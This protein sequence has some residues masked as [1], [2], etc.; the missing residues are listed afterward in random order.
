MNWINNAGCWLTLAGICSMCVRADSLETSKDASEAW[1]SNKPFA[2]GTWSTSI[3]LGG[4]LD[5]K[6]NDEEPNHDFGFVSVQVGYNLTGLVGQNSW[7]RGYW[8][9]SG[10]VFGGGQIQPTRYL[11]G[12]LPVLSYNF[13]LN[14][15]WV[16]FIEG[17]GGVAI[18]D[19]GEPDLSTTFQFNEQVGGGVRFGLNDA[20]WLRLGV[21][22]MHVSNGG[23]KEPNTGVTT[24]NLL[25]GVEWYY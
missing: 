16:P 10:E 3:L 24:G 2:K 18:T 8:Q 23:I 17:G 22:L 4:A 14:D 20:L 19:I 15:R 13:V 6:G 9:L 12:V 7:Y 5:L 25:L 1:Q 21:R 11:I